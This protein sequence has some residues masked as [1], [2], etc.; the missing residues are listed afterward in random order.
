MLINGS[1]GCRH[2]SGLLTRRAWPLAL[3]RSADR[4]PI[5]FASSELCPV[6]G[7][8]QSSVTTDVH[9]LLLTPCDQA[10]AVLWR[11]PMVFRR[12]PPPVVFYNPPAGP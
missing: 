12:Q 2:V 7:L 9:Q 11:R 5:N 1:V 4:V 10:V 8:S 6:F 3:M